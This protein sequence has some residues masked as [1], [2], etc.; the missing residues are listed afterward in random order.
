MALF[1]W[2]KPAAP[3]VTNKVWKTQAARL[4]GTMKE[5]LLAI[6]AGQTPV[7]IV[8]FAESRQVLIHGLEQSGIPHFVVDESTAAQQSVC[9]VDVGKD[10][11]LLKRIPSG[12]V[13]LFWMGRYP[14]PAREAEC[15][16]QIRTH[17]PDAPGCYCLSLEDAVFDVF[18]GQQLAPLLE[19]LGLGEDEC[20]EHKLVDKAIDNALQKVGSA[21]TL[22]R[23]ATS[24]KQWFTLNYTG[25]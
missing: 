25:A 18:A 19:K 20:I 4:R 21:V 12:P 11:G 7:V 10:M 23:K 5:C 17:H 2:G 9:I 6:K 13:S 24:E 15:I 1:S 16:A 3:V 8:W 14:L 22:E